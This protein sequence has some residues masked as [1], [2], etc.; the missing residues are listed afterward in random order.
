MEKV[1]W[2]EVEKRQVAGNCV[3]TELREQ[4]AWG[5]QGP[6]G[7]PGKENVSCNF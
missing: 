5:W 6:K 3:E 2:K 4:N 1:F 7:M